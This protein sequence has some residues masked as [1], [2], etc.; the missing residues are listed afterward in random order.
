MSTSGR[1]SSLNGDA[2]RGNSKRVLV[3]GGLLLALIAGVALA[4]FFRPAA[5]TGDVAESPA[6][7]VAGEPAEPTLQVLAQPEQSVSGRLIQPTPVVVLADGE[8]RP[9][10]GATVSVRSVPEAFVDG[11]VTKAT[12]DAEGRAV[13][14]ALT[15]EKSGSYCLIFS[16]EG[17]PKTESANFIVRFGAPR[18]LTVVREPQSGPVGSPVPG[19]PAVLVTDLAGNPVPRVN[20]D[21]AVNGSSQGAA[22]ATVPTDSEGI[23]AFPD[24]VIPDPGNDYRLKF[25]ARAAGIN[26]A[27]SSVFS[28]TNS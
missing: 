3:G 14:N 24:L 2:Q 12:T 23:A 7:Q 6:A 19:N 5:E 4:V 11:S 13:F 20:V 21:V 10:S 16:A 15:I 9:V 18:V 26:D 22:L 8:G 25:N 1:H 17:Y 28:L 27:L